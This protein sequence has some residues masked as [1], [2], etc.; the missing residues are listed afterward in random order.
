MRGSPWQPSEKALRSIQ[1][2]TMIFEVLRF[3]MY[4]HFERKSYLIIIG[5][6]VISLTESSK[7]FRMIHKIIK[8]RLGL[9]HII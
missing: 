9:F 7:A 8:A 1:I 2:S 3:L 5:L 4:E 6:G